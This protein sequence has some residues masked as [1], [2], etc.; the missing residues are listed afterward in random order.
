[1]TG[2]PVYQTYGLYCGSPSRVLALKLLGKGK[3]K[4]RKLRHAS[5][6]HLHKGISCLSTSCGSLRRE[7]GDK[8]NS[9]LHMIVV[10]QHAVALSESQVSSIVRPQYNLVKV[11]SAMSMRADDPAMA[12]VSKCYT[13]EC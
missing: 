9:S 7:S 5:S 2:C 6:N 10:L 13:Q 12:S 11:T 4:S 1:M 3:Q 8:S